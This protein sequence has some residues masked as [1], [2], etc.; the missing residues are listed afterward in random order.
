M[1]SPLFLALASYVPVRAESII[2]DN[3]VIEV[4][5]TVEPTIEP[6]V[7][8]TLEPTLEPSLSPIPTPIPI[9]ICSN[10]IET[11]LVDSNWNIDSQNH[12]AE[13]VSAVELGT[14]YRFPF[15]DKVSLT[16]NCLPGD[17]DLRSSL[18][19]QRVAVSSI[20]LPEDVVV[21]GDYAYDIT[22]DMVDGTFKYSLEL[23]KQE[24]INAEVKYIEKDLDQIQTQ[25]L[26]ETDLKSIRADQVTQS[27]E[28]IK[29]SNLDH[30]TLFVVVNPNSTDHMDEVE[31]QNNG[32]VSD[33]QYAIF[34]NRDDRAEYGFTNLGIP[35]GSVIDGIEVFIEGKT[36]GRDLDV[37]LWNQ[38]GSSPDSF[39]TTKT[40]DLDNS[41][42]T[43][44]LGS[45]TDKW[46][47][48]W[49]ANDFD[50]DFMVRIDANSG[51]NTASLDMV[52]VK[53]YYHDPL[54]I[55]LPVLPNDSS[56]DY[57]LSSVG[58][59]WIAIN[60]GSGHTG[61]N[62]NEVRWGEP[63]SS[64]KSG[65]R[66][67]GTGVQTFDEGTS[68]LLGALTHM[69]WP[70]YGG[71]AANG[72]TLQITLTFT[73]PGIT[74]NPTFTYDFLI[75][76]TS[77]SFPCDPWQISGTPCDDMITFPNSYGQQTFTIGDKLYTLKIDGF[78]NSFP[79]GS[80]V[81]Q[82][83]TEEY[84]NNS[85]YLVGHLSSVLVEKPDITIVKSTNGDDAQTVPGP[86]LYVGD[87][88]NWTY[89]VQ[90]TGNVT[91]NN[92]LVSDDKEGSVTC[93]KTTLTP[94]ENMTCVKTGTAIAGQYVNTGSVKANHTS[95]SVSDSDI[96]HY[97]G[98]TKG[99]LK[100]QKT[101]I[102]AG[103]QQEF[104]ILASG[105]GTITGGGA[106]V[107]T[108]ALDKTYEVTAGTY[109]VSETVPS[110]WEMTKNTCKDI[111]VAN[112]QT[113][114]C[115]IENTYKYAK[116]TVIKEVKNDNGGTK[117][118]SD[119]KLYVNGTQV[120]SG[121]KND[122]P[123]NTLLTL[124]EDN[125][126]G[127]QAGSWGG[128]CSA[129]GQ[130][131]LQPGDDKTCTITNDDIQPTL[132]VNKVV[133]GGDKVIADFPLYVGAIQVVSGVKNGFNAGN[134]VIS[135]T[136]QEGY[137]A[138][139]S[140]DCDAQG[141]ISLSIGDVK[142]CTIT[143]TRDTGSLRVRK[144]TDTNADGNFELGD[145]GSNDL[146]FRW[147]IGAVMDQS[148]NTV[149]SGLE[150]GS[151]NVNEN[152]VP[153]YHFYSWFNA[154]D[155]SKTCSN[156][157]GYA[158]PVSVNVSKGA[159]ANIVLCNTRDTGILKVQKVVDDNTDLSLWK[160][161][162]NDGN[163]VFADNTGL[164]DF[165]T[166][167]T[168]SNYTITESGPLGYQLGSISGAN[169]VQNING[170]ASASVLA[171]QTTVCT[172]NNLVDKVSI[173][174]IKDAV[175]NSNEVF[176]FNLTGGVSRTFQLEDD[177]DENDGAPSQW[178]ISSLLPGTYTLSEAL[179]NPEWKLTDLTCTSSL[180]RTIQD[181][182]NS[183]TF[184]L[185][186]GESMTCT[187]TNTQLGKVKALKY[188]DLDGDGDYSKDEGAFLG[189]WEMTLYSGFDCQ[190]PF[191]DVALTQAGGPAVFAGL[192]PGNYSVRETMQGDWMATDG[193]CRNYTIT[194]GQEQA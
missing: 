96:S 163:W 32:W 148:F 21:V 136:N 118:V 9:S 10:E 94:G 182:D 67:D 117:Q 126:P 81:S 37:S 139:F 27:A 15:D 33:N 20:N 55:T 186:P 36:G 38:S 169:C 42:A 65:L 72:A 88:V 77:N 80:P 28:V 39:T 44:T 122:Y 16:F 184:T 60:G 131:T 179:S 64:E 110:N 132:T 22:T 69:N 14:I 194:A 161:K 127:Y 190:G 191:L 53:V 166:Q 17:I 100:V 160:F 112:G 23:P 7:E 113:A 153:G 4:T 62:T 114:T 45:P 59:I 89:M 25:E 79:S 98:L 172:F 124:S 116:L 135:E 119:F 1:F 34:N 144:L 157:D 46:G 85:A 147:G 30:F 11:V 57:A 180:Q 58:G 174:V 162:L 78:V 183:V 5:P 70:V 83:I 188:N 74:P 51:G 141:N 52:Q 31:N 177:G 175:A 185:V 111:V 143:N 26:L 173:T 91:L 68:F 90:N 187:F 115:Q 102:P 73:K 145:S 48:T 129:N 123:V 108:D 159:T 130:I 101:T 170:S 137:S 13:T 40:A 95:G 12:S 84:K 2:T 125:L 109:S 104:S 97:Y 86:N 87:S 66:F 19:I 181:P 105:T 167:V 43:I 133:N 76:E 176:D 128:A 138:S 154:D 103:S 192:E 61:L 156:P 24:N 149:M 29:A 171:N 49:T 8:P 82:F 71:T 92:I 106:G 142:S 152:T 6:T 47:K 134:Y 158:L 3:T 193:L 121:V 120:I 99:Y 146:G 155:P 178:S 107:I 168:G 50:S 165:G 54:A 41:E 189:G 164:V 151:Y 140:G 56:D 75:N 63:A 35:V 18:K 93:P 150:T